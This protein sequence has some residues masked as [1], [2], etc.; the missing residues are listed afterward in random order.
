MNVNTNYG[1]GLV[2]VLG[3]FGCS[4]PSDSVFGLGFRIPNQ[5]AEATARGNAFVATADNPSALYYNPAGITQLEGQN[6]QFGLHALSV[7]SHFKAATGSIEADTDFEILPVPELYYVYSPKD[8]PL[9][10]GLGV[11]VPFGLGLQWPEICCRSCR[12]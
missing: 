8:Y 11:Y 3:L 6:V 1:R 5:D 10:F 2:M 4:H 9:A 7:N 12:T